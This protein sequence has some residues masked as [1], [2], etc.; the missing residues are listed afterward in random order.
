M[1]DYKSLIGRQWEYKISDCYSIVRDY[2]SLL[3]INLPDYKRPEDVDTCQSVFLKYVP[4]F[5][6]EVNIN[7]RKEND[8][9]V[10]KI[11]TKE[12]MHGAILLKND[13][14]LH[15]KFESLSC[16]EYFSDYYRRKTV[17]CFRYAA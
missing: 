3:G 5:F 1:V 8:L 13:M 17:G 14:I 16:T 6:K 12:P 9:L 10:M 7:N 2:Y 15:Q 4:L 11:L